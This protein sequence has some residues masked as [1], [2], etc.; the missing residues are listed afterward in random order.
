M[1]MPCRFLGHSVGDG[2]AN[3]ALDEALLDEV[4]AHPESAIFRTYAWSVP[5]L[6]LGY[7]QTIASAHA[8]PRFDGVPIVRRPTGGGALW[9][10]LEITYA[11]VVPAP[12]P[13]ARPNTRL[14]RAVHGAIANLL[15]ESGIEASRCGDKALEIERNN[16]R[17]FL[18]FTDRDAEDI[19]VQNWKVLGSAQRRRDGATLQHGSIVLGRS[20]L[21]PEVLGV[22]D[23][24]RT[25][26][27]L[28]AWPALISTRIEAALDLQFHQSE[29]PDS[30]RSRAAGYEA[31]RYRDSAW[32]RLR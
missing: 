28:E 6:S 32:T 12:H 1:P 13:L 7:F 3:M 15:S 24:A 25:T 16:D 2:P 26:L 21:V 11:V 31:S 30:V 22:G 18:C 14:Y 27:E 20:P 10:D 4:S 8:D 29:I 19:I 5:T 9:H 23:L 17:S